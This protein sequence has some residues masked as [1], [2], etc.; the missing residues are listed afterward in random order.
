MFRKDGSRVRSRRKRARSQAALQRVSAFACEPLEARRLLTLQFQFNGVTMIVTD[1]TADSVIE[2]KQTGTAETP[3]IEFWLDGVLEDDVE[4]PNWPAGIYLDGASGNDTLIVN[5]NVSSDFPVTLQGGDGNDSLVGGNNIDI[6]I[7][8]AGNDTLK[9]NGGS[10][11]FWGGFGVDIAN[12]SDRTVGQSITLDNIANDG[13]DAVADGT[14]TEADNVYDEMENILGGSGS[15]YLV[16]SSGANWIGGQNGADTIYGGSGD[17]T[18]DG[19]N[20]ND[21]IYGQGNNDSLLG[22]SGNDWM[23][24]GLHGDVLIG[25]IGDDT[26]WG[27]GGSDGLW[28]GDGNDVLNAQD[29]EVDTG[30]GGPDADTI[31]KDGIDSITG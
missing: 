5:A 2:I 24:G 6:L 23:S 8:G 21:S 31:N 29:D 3:V 18:L 17:D 1:S 13:E 10:D 27:D 19:Q 26:L 22:G 14:S 12:Y 20:G 4:D 16:G 15:D 9:G 30:S 7:G 28:G 11:G 25:D